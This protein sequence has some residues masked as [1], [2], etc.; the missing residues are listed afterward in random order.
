MA[1]ERA[2]DETPGGERQGRAADA[3]KRVLAR[4]G[5]MAG[6][7]GPPGPCLVDLR[8]IAGKRGLAEDVFRYGAQVVSLPS[9]LDDHSGMMMELS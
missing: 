6:H 7:Q 3:G 8:R 4:G 9:F 1:A 5:E 2:V